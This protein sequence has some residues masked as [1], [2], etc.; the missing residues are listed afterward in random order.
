IAL[1]LTTGRTLWRTDIGSVARRQGV[2]R[3]KRPRAPVRDAA[4]PWQNLSA[5]CASGDSL[6][7][8]PN[9]GCAIALD[10][11]DGHL[12]WIRP[13]DPALEPERAAATAPRG[14]HAA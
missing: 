11:F 8:A 10:R 2:T 14:A 9:A 13:Y 12:R 6:Y 7:V 5:P 4:D 1:E 3:Y